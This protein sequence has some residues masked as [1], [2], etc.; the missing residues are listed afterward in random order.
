MARVLALLL[1]VGCTV[2]PTTTDGATPSPADAAPPPA[3]PSGNEG[4][5]VVEQ[6]NGGARACNTDA[7]CGDGICEGEGCGDMQ[8][9]CAPKTGRMCTRDLR[10]Y[11]GCD[12]QTF[13]GSGSCPGKR[14]AKT[15]ECASALPD[16][17][18]C[19]SAQQCAS[20]ICEGE[21]CY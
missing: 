5:G 6:P 14:F 10:T 13:Q 18:K 19:T 16:G 17:S 9:R 8:G 3:A 2:G 4:S 20:G 12:G 11:C 15:G 1:L 7:D 21:G